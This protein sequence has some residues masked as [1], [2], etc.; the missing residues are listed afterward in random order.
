MGKPSRDKGKRGEREVVNRLK[1]LGLD[2]YTVRQYRG[3]PDSPDV[4][5]R[6]NR[7]VSIEVKHVETYSVNQ[8]RAW[9]AKAVEDAEGRKFVA[10]IH[11]R[12]HTDWMVEMSIE[13]YA[14]LVKGME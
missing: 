14:E 10:L 11:R 2:A 9:Y 4:L 7:E 1:A 8:L 13:A 5:I 3:G 12:N 6:N